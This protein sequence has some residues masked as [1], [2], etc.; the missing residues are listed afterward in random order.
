[1]NTAKTRLHD[2]NPDL[3]PAW[4]RL[5]R[6]AAKALRAGPF[7]V[8]Q[9][10][11]IPPSGD[12]H[13]YYSIAPYAWP[14]SSKPD[15]LPY[16]NRDGQ[17]NPDNRIGTDTAT[18]DRMA[19]NMRTLALAYSLTNNEN[20]AQHAALLLRTWFL[21]PATR[22]NPHLN[23]GQ[24]IPGRNEGRGAGIIETHVLVDIVDAAGMLESSR[25]GPRMIAKA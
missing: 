18:F 2:S 5:R 6:D 9:K 21:D 15:G 4:E 22:M 17:V 7:S 1:M 8:M 14:D 20:Y 24:A 11:K 3:G 16:L 25:H 13:D 12:K 10:S 19:W 23:F